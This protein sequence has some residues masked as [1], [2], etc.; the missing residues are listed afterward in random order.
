MCTCA[1]VCACMWAPTKVCWC[2]RVHV[3]A[4]ACVCACKRAREVARQNRAS[5]LKS[6]LIHA[7]IAADKTA[8]CPCPGDI[9][10]KCVIK[11]RPK[12][13]NSLIL[14][15]ASQTEQSA[16]WEQQTQWREGGQITWS[17]YWPA[18]TLVNQLSI[19]KEWFL[20]LHKG[21]FISDQKVHS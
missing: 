17:L 12:Q 13:D 6:M 7:A 1:R 21:F 2:V 18:G 4:C 16:F 14:T 19:L 20:L 9:S 3:R 15:W 8:L 11:C 5:H 10:C